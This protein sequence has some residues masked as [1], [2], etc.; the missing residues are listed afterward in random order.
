MSFSC[1]TITRFCRWGASLFSSQLIIILPILALGACVSSPQ[2]SA[3]S[4]PDLQH[5]SASNPKYLGVVEPIPAPIKVRLVPF[6]PSQATAYFGLSANGLIADRGPEQTAPALVVKIVHPLRVA[7]ESFGRR[8]VL[9]LHPRPDVVG[10]AECA[11]PRFL[12]HAPRRSERRSVF[13]GPW[14]RP[15]SRLGR[16]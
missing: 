12:G 11:E 1:R 3:L 13:L 5:A 7:A 14:P 2:I 16:R 6:S 4:L 15:C 8:Y 10:V 9:D